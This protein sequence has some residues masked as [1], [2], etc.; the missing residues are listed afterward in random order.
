[1]RKA[2]PDAKFAEP[3]PAITRPATRMVGCGDAHAYNT[4]PAKFRA[5]D[6]RKTSRYETLSLRYPMR[7]SKTTCKVNQSADAANLL[8]LHQACHS[9]RKLRL[10]LG[11]KVGASLTFRPHPAQVV[12]GA[13][14][15][16]EGIAGKHQTIPFGG[17]THATCKELGI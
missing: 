9:V 6:I 17:T 7:G 16:S 14:Y 4:L 1:M 10:T 13:K 3:A 12:G 5:T 15:L 8:Q 2:R 11:R